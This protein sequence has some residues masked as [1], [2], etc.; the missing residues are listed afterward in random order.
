MESALGKT[1]IRDGYESIRFLH[2]RGLR[3]ARDCPVFSPP[4]FSVQTKQSSWPT[5][6]KRALHAWTMTRFLAYWAAEPSADRVLICSIQNGR[7]NCVYNS[8]NAGCGRTWWSHLSSMNGDNPFSCAEDHGRP[9]GFRKKCHCGRI[10][11][12]MECGALFLHLEVVLTR[13]PNVVRRIPQ[14]GI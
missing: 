10:A 14:L 1:P 5:V 6:R 2:E 9:P 4:N 11:M 13:C 12:R 8:E 3:N 7:A